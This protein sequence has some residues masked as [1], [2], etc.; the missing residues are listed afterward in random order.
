MTDYITRGE[1]RAKFQA[2]GLSYDLIRR[3]H[4]ELLR[5]LLIV[6]FHKSRKDHDNDDYVYPTLNRH[7]DFKRKHGRLVF[8]NLSMSGKYFDDRQ[9][10]TFSGKDNFI[11]FAGWASDGNVQPVLRAFCKWCEVIAE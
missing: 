10:I 2:C 4:I 9:C 3:R 1:A 11:G 8:A 7:Y 5:A 6:E